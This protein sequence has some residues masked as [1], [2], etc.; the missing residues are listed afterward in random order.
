MLDISTTELLDTTGKSEI[1]KKLILA[2]QET[3]G[4]SAEELL[5]NLA[6]DAIGFGLKVLLALA[7]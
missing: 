4:L 5:S 3:S 1:A 7:L 2:K 6:Q